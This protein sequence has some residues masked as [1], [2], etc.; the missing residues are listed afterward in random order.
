[1]N[2]TGEGK[3]GASIQHLSHEKSPEYQIPMKNEATQKGMP[4]I[5]LAVP[6]ERT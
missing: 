2:T 6:V 4:F 1:M 3:V 5:D